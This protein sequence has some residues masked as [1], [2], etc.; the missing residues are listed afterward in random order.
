MNVYQCPCCKGLLNDLYDAIETGVI[1]DYQA[2]E[3]DILWP[4]EEEDQ[5]AYELAHTCAGYLYCEPCMVAIF[6]SDARDYKRFGNAMRDC[7]V[8][9]GIDD[10]LR[11]LV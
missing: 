9:P 11:S 3:M 5:E 7:V 8:D 4:V 1:K 10:F 6:W 2:N